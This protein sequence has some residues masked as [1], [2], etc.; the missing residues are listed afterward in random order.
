MESFAEDVRKGLSGK[1]KHLPSKYFYDERGSKLFQEI[2]S[3]EEYYPTRCEYDILNAHKKELCRLFAGSGDDFE[4]VEL[5]AGDGMKTKILLRCLA[6]MRSELTYLPIDI[7][8]SILVELTHS[9]REEL[10]SITTGAITGDYFEALSMLKRYD[11]RRRVLLFLGSTIGNFT[12]QEAIDF[13]SELGRHMNSGDL[14]VTGFDL[15]KHP[16]IIAE[17]Y[18]DKSGVTRAFNLNLLNRI[19]RELEGKF[20]ISQFEHYPVYDPMNGEAKSFIISTCHQSVEIGKAGTFEFKSG[21]AI[22]TEISKKY[23]LEGIETLA[24]KSGFRI[25]KNFQDNNCYFTDSVWQLL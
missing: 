5:G 20:D 2:M 11:S 14:L 19:N 12:E 3:L 1:L 17:A 25:I 23:T 22:Y 21:E 16:R 10:P 24:V 18:N 4:L 8:P 9:V 13:M 6:S 15:Q 7:S